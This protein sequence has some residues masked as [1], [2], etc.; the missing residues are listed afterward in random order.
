[1]NVYERNRRVFLENRELAVT[2]YK[3]LTEKLL[4][5]TR[6]FTEPLKCKKPDKI[7]ACEVSF[8]KNDTVSSSLAAVSK[9]YK[10]CA[11]NFADAYTPGGLVFEGEVTQEEDI[12][13]CSNLYESLVKP[14]CLAEYY[15][16]NKQNHSSAFT[17]RVIYSKGVALIRESKDYTLLDEPVL[18][19]V[20]TCPAPLGGC[21]DYENVME[22]RIRGIL[23]AAAEMGSDTLILGAY[24]CGAFGGDAN[25]V[26]RLFAKVLCEFKCFD[27]IVFS[28]KGS[29]DRNY[30]RL[31]N[32]YN[33]YN[34]EN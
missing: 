32:G 14:E 8:D 19:D 11:L 5:E 18:C 33:S 29:N 30:K 23:S 22:Q 3:A 7:G 10:T 4:S 34:I 12:C 16:F 6:V 31:L 15:G 1:M 27:R 9:G 17:D 13:R 21:A 28:V 24:G 26:G 20:I 25:K 2:K